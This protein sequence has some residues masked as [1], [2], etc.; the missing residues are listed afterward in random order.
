MRPP[1]IETPP[2][3]ASPE[4][5]A[6]IV[7]SVLLWVALLFASTVVWGDGDAGHMRRDWW[8]DGTLRL[9][10]HLRGNVFHGPYR[11]WYPDGQP[12][13]LRRYEGGREVG[14]QRAW[15]PDGELYI[16]YEVWHGRRY[17]YVNAQPCV[18][19]LEE[20]AVS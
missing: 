9:E 17:G 3:T 14:R 7:F 2:G 12:Y 5:D 19:V 13:Q 4:G 20:G 6:P 10:A 16:N 8:P 1:W 18:P 11:S 15:T